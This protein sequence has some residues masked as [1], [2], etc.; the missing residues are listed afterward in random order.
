[1]VVS[2]SLSR[3][4]MVDQL[5][6]LALGIPFGFLVALLLAWQIASV[7]VAVS[8]SHQIVA[9]QQVDG[10]TGFELARWAKS[11]WWFTLAPTLILLGKLNPRR[12]GLIWPLLRDGN[13]EASER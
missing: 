11:R 2:N 4:E 10:P 13:V 8:L 3:A 1:M 9:L 5:I 12:F 6:Y 7:F